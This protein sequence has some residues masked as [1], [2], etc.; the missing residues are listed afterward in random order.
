VTRVLVCVPGVPHR[1]RGASSVLFFHYIEQLK[2]AGYRLHC[3]LR[4]ARG[5]GAH[6][7]PAP[8]RAQLEE[9]GR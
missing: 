5:T 2:Q 6:W 1:S 7:D 4:I 3:L 8:F 9:P